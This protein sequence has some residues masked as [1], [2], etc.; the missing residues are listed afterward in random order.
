MSHEDGRVIA[1]GGSWGSIT[2]ILEL[3]KGLS[4]DLQAAICIVIHLSPRFPS[5]AA[6]LFAAR[7]PMPVVAATDGARLESGRVFVGQPDR[8]LIV[9]DGTIRLG[10]GP[11]E[12]QA[13]PA[14]DPL[15]RSV[16]VSYGARAVGLVLTGLL[17]DGASGLADLKR[18]GGVT[19]VQNP[20][21][22]EA[23]EMPL[24]ALGATAID[25]RAPLADLGALLEMLTRQPAGPSPPPP[26]D[27]R[28]EVEIALGR[29]IGAEDMARLA[30][31]SALSCPACGGVLSQMRRAPPLRFRCQ[32]GHAYSAETLNREQEGSVD[33][34]MRVAL[35]I[36]EE[37]STLTRKMA[38][39]ARNAGR[40][41]SAA[42]F[43]KTAEEAR[44]Q[45]EVLRGAI[46]DAL[47]RDRAPDVEA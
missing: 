33:E 1:I 21:D 24:A 34:A 43:D 28:L 23:A 46:M 45:S 25:Y 38:A 16:G 5:Q 12:N 17:D 11:R 2:A 30:E 14:I 19:V 3:C 47:R 4:S 10:D 9:Q 8:H 32:V 15:F 6:Q 22:A 37:R 39:E 29:P 27:V 40:K 35:R 42:L 20:R 26:D 31:P 44:K 13:R 7:C 18:C 36:V 41:A